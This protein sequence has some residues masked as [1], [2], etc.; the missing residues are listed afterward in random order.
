[1][2]NLY[3]SKATTSGFSIP[4]LSSRLDGLLL[5]LKSCKGITCRRPWESLFPSGE[6][7]HLRHAMKKKY[8]HFFQRQEKVSFS[9]CLMGYVTSAE[10][11]LKSESYTGHF[12]DRNFQARWED[13]V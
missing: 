7:N 5:T 1:M 2:N 10:G 3:G 4:D 9:A 6:V 8:D 11:A 13:W 12:E